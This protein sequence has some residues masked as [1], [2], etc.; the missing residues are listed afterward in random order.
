MDAQIFKDI[1]V[2]RLLDKVREYKEDSWRFVQICASTIESG[3][4]L[5]YS[6]S[7]DGILENLRLKIGEDTIIP[8]ISSLFPAAFVFENETHDLFGVD[9]EGIAIDFKGNFY[10]VSIPTPMN[11]KSRAAIAAAKDAGKGS[12]RTDTATIPSASAEEN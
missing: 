1:E 9:I 7:K 6:F 2:S 4:E 12:D 3:V 10:K 11:P 5:L 8:S